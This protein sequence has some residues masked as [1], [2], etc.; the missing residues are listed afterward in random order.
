VYFI[1]CS[2]LSVLANL[3]ARKYTSGSAASQAS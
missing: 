3:L 2:S 1:F